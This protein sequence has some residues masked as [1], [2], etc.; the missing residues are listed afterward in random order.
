MLRGF[1]RS[2]NLQPEVQILFLYRWHS[3]DV[4]PAFFFPNNK[5][6]WSQEIS[7]ETSN[8]SQSFPVFGQRNSTSKRKRRKNNSSH[9]VA[10]WTRRC[11][12]Y[13]L[14]QI[15]WVKYVPGYRLHFKNCPCPCLGIIQGMFSAL[16]DGFP[17]LQ[18]ES[19]EI[20]TTGPKE[21]SWLDTARQTRCCLDVTCV[22]F[23]C[24][25]GPLT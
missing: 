7:D 12:W 20:S 16:M 1:S 25:D 17:T 15:V 6:K 9:P 22:I 3:R 23:H 2:S 10:E 18:T 14:M 19:L 5:T 8:T 4:Q 11:W 24:R 13:L 21:S